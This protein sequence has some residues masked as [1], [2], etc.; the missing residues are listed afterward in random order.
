MLCTVF[1]V[2]IFANSSLFLRCYFNLSHILLAANYLTEDSFL[3]A[4]NIMDHL[5]RTVHKIV[6]TT[7]P[8]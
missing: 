7:P 2:E 1:W 8:R 5:Q 6:Q 4:T 3:I